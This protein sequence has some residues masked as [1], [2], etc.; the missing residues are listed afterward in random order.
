MRPS[1]EGGEA[2]VE[3]R[4][5]APLTGDVPGAEAEAP[6]ALGDRAAG[7]T[8]FIFVG[9]AIS[10]AMALVLFGYLARTFAPAGLGAYNLV[11]A[12]SSVFLLVADLG[13]TQYL[14]RELSGHPHDRRRLIREAAAGSLLLGLLAFSLCNV[15][16]LAA[17]YSSQL[18]QWILIASLQTLFAPAVAAIAIPQSELRGATVARLAVANRAI[19]WVF[20][21]FAV[22][23]GRGIG[24]IVVL[25]TIQHAIYAMM[26]VRTSGALR[27]YRGT[28]RRETLRRALPVAR[29][30]APLGLVAVIAIVYYRVDTFVLS[31]VKDE[32]AVGFYSA[33]WRLTEALGLVPTAVSM[34]MLSLS[35][36]RE[37][38][39]KARTALAL[40]R[41]FRYL[42]LI[43]IPI[44]VAGCIL[45]VEILELV[46]GPSLTPARTAF[47]VLL[48]AE[49]ILFFGAVAAATLTGIGRIRPL[50]A[51][52][53]GVVPLNVLACVLLLPEYSFNG[54]AWI[55][56]GSELLATLLLMHVVRRELGEGL[57]L[58]PRM[59]VIKSL[60]ACVPMTGAILAA[61]AMDAHVV[62]AILAGGAAYVLALVL[63]RG[64]TGDDLALVRRGLTLARS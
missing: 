16:A 36:R 43:G 48:G 5:R 58:I 14:T 57:R 15:L 64:V 27:L 51:I 2:D 7:S 31:L 39:A 63:V 32:T 44:V 47:R 54:A 20:V 9:T 19:G 62:L 22:L 17:G 13:M 30:A 41:S 33:A 45:A 35:G 46:Y 28:F 1:G 40:V 55:S 29:A 53:A 4:V 34:T 49:L 60:M 6:A 42:A 11:I 61:G 50:L 3:G 12:F 52:E 18:T 21:L 24:T 37:Q 25:M 38:G 23:T 8:V 59:P 26:V 10:Q 56:L